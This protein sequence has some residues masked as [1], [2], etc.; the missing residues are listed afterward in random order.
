M[1]NPMFVLHLDLT[2]KAGLLDSLEQAY[3][4]AFVPA[5][6]AQEGFVRVELLRP[7]E[8]AGPLRMIIAFSDHAV[9]QRWV[10]TDL[11][12]DVWGQIERCCDAVSLSTYT[13]VA[14]CP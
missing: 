13:P 1:V 8:G 10:A 3:C 6:S 11:H 5:L 9:Q 12:Q 7:T 4:T 14:P 2:I